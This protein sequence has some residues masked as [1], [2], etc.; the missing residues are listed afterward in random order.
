MRPERI[1]VSGGTGLVGRFI[2]E[3]LLGDGREVALFGRNRPAPDTFRVPLR[4]VEG[5]LEPGGDW[6]PA[7]AGFDGFVHAA[8]D[9][10]P[11]RFRGGEGDDAAGFV[12]RNRDGTAALFEA[13]GAAGVARIVFL[14]S[15]AVYGDRRPARRLLETTTAEPDT[16]YGE[17]KLAGERHL[18]T[19]AATG[20]V[21]ASLRATGVYGPAPPGRAHKWAGL[22]ADFLAGR[23]VEPRVATEVHGD[24][25]AA[26][27][28]LLLD[29]P[30]ALVAGRAFN[31]SDLTV[32]RH[33][34]LTL[35]GRAAGRS[36]PLPHRADATALSVMATDRLMALGWRPR[37]SAGLEAFVRSVVGSDDAMGQ[38]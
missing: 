8:F 37:G 11:G 3:R 14:S 27:V 35:A 12:R 10:L 20:L 1:L 33:D 4:F 13:A 29:A 17:V 16:L 6:R 25:V 34:L 21:G 28:S 9:H 36:L 18:S 15:R 31:V 23:P 2:V 30:A 32:D 24:D 5:S 7:F 26:A 19:L 22:F 38:S